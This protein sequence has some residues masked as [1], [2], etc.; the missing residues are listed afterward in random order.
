[1]KKI[2][3]VDDEPD[4]EILIRQKFKKNISKGEYQ[5][6]F[7]SSGIE[8]LEKAKTNT[9][10]DLILTD[11]NM[12]E[13]DGLTL[14]AK[15][16]ELNPLFQTIVISAY[17]DM[18]NIRMAM[19]A[20]A[21]DFL[22]KPINLQDLEFTI[23]K[24]LQHVQ[25]TK[26]TRR[27]LYK[28]QMQL[29]EKEKMSALGEL[30]AAVAQEITNPLNFI[31]GNLQHTEDYIQG[32]VKHLQLYQRHYPHPSPEI[33]NHAEEIDLKLILS[34][35]PQIIASMKT[36]TDRISKTSTFVRTFSRSSTKYKENFN[37]H[38]GINSTLIILDHRLKANVKRPAIKII[39]EYGNL[40]LIYCYGSQLNQVFMNILTNAIDALEKSNQKRT[41]AE[42]EANPN[43]I[44]IRTEFQEDDNRVIVSIKDNGLGMSEESKQAFDYL[45][46]IKAVG[47]DIRLG[48]PISRQIIE[49]KHG[50][51]LRC[52]SQLGVGTEFVIELTV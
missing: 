8:A 37:I 42:I 52:I 48:L 31:V 41:F 44:K 18:N 40:P 47:K 23:Q 32:L 34:D 17:G 25:Q 13:M 4:I 20:G 2:L 50:G 26:E 27:Q 43:L 30:I 46:S 28:M 1:M 22:T 39:Q 35:L 10:L 24:G 45:F 33:E 51:K 7:A 3:F 29:A 49:D 15:L 16:Q 38:K 11:I 19:N 5:L 9:D 14:L 12:P 6:I 36:G 21:F